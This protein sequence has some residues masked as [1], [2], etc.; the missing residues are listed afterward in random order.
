[1]YTNNPVAGLGI[2]VVSVPLV[3]VTRGGKNP[4]SVADT[5]SFAEALGVVVPMP[6]WAIIGNEIHTI[7]KRSCFFISIFFIYFF[8][9]FFIEPN[10][11]L[12][13]G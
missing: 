4:L 12:F 7:R 13:L 9:S 3:K 2:V 6:V 10:T 1:L 5:S 8:N 11:R